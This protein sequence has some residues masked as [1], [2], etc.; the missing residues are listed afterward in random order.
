MKPLWIESFA[1]RMETVEVKQCS[2]AY[3]LINVIGASQARP[4]FAPKF[5]NAYQAQLANL[6][7]LQRPKIA[8]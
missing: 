8:H 2:H 5:Q 3:A 7:A 4:F 1:M 6:K